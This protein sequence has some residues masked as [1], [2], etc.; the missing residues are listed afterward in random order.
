MLY[1]H[2]D[3]PEARVEDV[4]AGIQEAIIN[5]IHL[6]TVRALERYDAQA[7]VVGGV[8]TNP[9]LRERLATVGV[10]TFSTF[11]ILYR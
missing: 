1:F 11:G 6:K 3:H 5:S 9:L 7:I 10:P 2:R 8:A 4:C